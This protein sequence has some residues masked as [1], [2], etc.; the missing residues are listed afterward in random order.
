MSNDAGTYSRLA[1]IAEETTDRSKVHP[2][3]LPL[4]RSSDR[5]AEQTVGALT[6]RPAGATTDLSTRPMDHRAYD[7]FKDQ[8]NWLNRQRLELK[9]HYGRLVPATVMVQLA[10]DLFIK[11][12]QQHGED[13]QLV[14]VL[15]KG[16]QPQT[17][18]KQERPAGEGNGG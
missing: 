12:F 5:P 7:F 2:A 1:E 9:E 10:L 17:A 4:D 8:V 13:S 3:E 6:G 11:D 15:I 14:R 18:S 16:E